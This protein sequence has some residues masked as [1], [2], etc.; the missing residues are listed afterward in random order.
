MAKKKLKEVWLKSIIVYHDDNFEIVRI[1]ARSGAF[2][3]S[4]IK[5]AIKW[6]CMSRVCG[7][8]ML[9]FNR[10]EVKI[11]KNSFWRDNVDEYYHCL[12]IENIYNPM[13]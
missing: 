11:W 9:D 3:D 8:A 12:E 13:D 5:E 1:E 6:L 10:I 4:C 7:S 2:L